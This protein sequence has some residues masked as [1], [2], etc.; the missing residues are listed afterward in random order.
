VNSDFFHRCLFSI[1]I[2][3]FFISGLKPSRIFP[4]D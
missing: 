4:A 2:G 1:I 3:C